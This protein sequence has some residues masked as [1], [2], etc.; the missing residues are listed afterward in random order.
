MWTSSATDFLPITDAEQPTQK[1]QYSSPY[2]SVSVT[3]WTNNNV[4][5]VIPTRGIKSGV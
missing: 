2:Q 4:Q 5:W 3:E 1:V